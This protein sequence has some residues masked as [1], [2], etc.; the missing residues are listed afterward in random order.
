[1]TE[2]SRNANRVLVQFANVVSG[3]IRSGWV[4]LPDGRP[5]KITL[6]HGNRPNEAV[7]RFAALRW[8]QSYENLSAGDLIRL[9]TDDGLGE[10][11][12]LFEGVFVSRVNG[13]TGGT[14]RESAAEHN[15]IVCR[16]YRWLYNTCNPI[17][18]VWA[19]GPDCYDNW[20]QPNQQAIAYRAQWFS[21][22]ACI[23]NEDGRPNR[24]PDGFLIQNDQRWPGAACTIPIF[25][26][27][28][29][30]EWWTVRQ[31]IVYLLAPM[32]NRIWTIC[33]I[34]NPAALPG[35][36][37]A[38]FDLVINSVDADRKRPID[39]VA[40]ICGRIGWTLREEYT[41]AGPQWV[42]Y[43][44]GYAAGSERTAQN[45]TILHTLYA[46]VPGESIAAAAARG[47]KMLWAAEFDESLDATINTPIGLGAPKVYEITVPLVPGWKDSRLEPDTSNE[48]KNLYLTES[49]LQREPNPDQYSFFSYYHPLGSSFRP[50]VGRKWVLNETGAYA[51]SGYNRGA[52]FDWASVL[53]AEEITDPQT[54]WRM[55]GPF[56]RRLLPCLTH[57]DGTLETVGVVVELSLDGGQSWQRFD[58]PVRLMRTECGIAIEQPNLSEILDKQQRKIS[59]GP[60]DNLELNYWTSLCDDILQQRAWPQWR[61]RVRITA[62]VQMD[63]RL[64]YA[65]QPGA[66]SASPYPQAAAVLLDEYTYSLRTDSSIFAESGLAAWNTDEGVKL[67]QQI[68]KLRAA[69]EDMAISGRFTLARMWCGDGAGV[70]TFQPGDGLEKLSGREYDL[71]ASWTE[72]AGVYPEIVQIIYDIQNQKEHLITRNLRFAEIR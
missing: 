15:V 34:V 51:G 18:G 45:R 71:F 50:E 24:D 43:K 66:A 68:D 67:A 63:E 44:P 42:F 70:P 37:H 30:A 64:L 11:S 4:T 60:L 53:P 48:M 35:L 5:E 47:E 57:Q 46:P 27:G 20:G 65:G 8:D 31:M 54:G 32:H 28:P 62:S 16:D 10:E 23:F 36:E 14:E 1:M 59:G 61:T 17:Y 6:N 58:G 12:V 22:R 49:Q 40:Q 52:P 69:N 25:G 19:R 13:F 29:N 26:G 41:A 56:A 72:G 7:I 38:D 9:I 33:P 21:G 55:Y 39:A 2:L 3:Q